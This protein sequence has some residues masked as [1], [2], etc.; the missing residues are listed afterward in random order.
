MEEKRQSRRKV[1]VRSL[2]HFGVC[3]SIANGNMCRDTLSASDAY[4]L[5]V[6]LHIH[7][8]TQSDEMCM[9][10]IRDTK[11]VIETLTTTC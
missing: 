2:H 1:N 11:N 9:N 10:A 3:L 6:P 4:A 5:A 8:S 7:T